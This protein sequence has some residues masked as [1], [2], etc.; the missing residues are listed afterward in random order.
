M[1]AKFF[2]GLCLVAAFFFACEEQQPTKRPKSKTAKSQKVDPNLPVYNAAEDFYV[3]YVSDALNE[4]TLDA[5]CWRNKE[6]RII[7][8]TAQ[9][10]VLPRPSKT[11]T[12]AVEVIAV[13]NGDW[14]AFRCKWKDKE[15][16][17]AAKLGEF[18]DALAIMFPLHQKEAPPVITMGSKNDPVHIFHW[19]AQYQKDK[20]QGP[21]SIKSMY[22]NMTT[23]MYPLEFDDM[24]HANDK[25]LL[26]ITQHQRE[27][28]S[29]GKASGNPQSFQKIRGVDEIVAEGFGS[30]AVIENALSFAYG[31]W[32]N[33]EWTLVI[34]RPMTHEGVAIIKPTAKTFAAF[35]VWQGGEQEVGSRKC[36]TLK[37]LPVFFAAKN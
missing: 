19:R 31:R 27:I 2:L 14:M 10:I 34:A 13:H 18:S 32:E 25:A 24:E 28:F 16:S 15:K 7:P 5:P 36:I 29:P 11:T 17:E 35:A 23:D 9:P 3:H 1:N 4:P 21:Q 30:S 33:G 20:E 8:L 37:W 22:P 12:E 26:A 6:A